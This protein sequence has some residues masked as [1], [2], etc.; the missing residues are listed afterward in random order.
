MVKIS[1][2]KKANVISALNFQIQVLIE[3]YAI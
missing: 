1:L 2:L 3:L